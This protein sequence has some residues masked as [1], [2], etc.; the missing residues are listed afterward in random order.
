[1]KNLKLSVI[2]CAVILLAGFNANTQDANEILQKVDKV[3]YSAKDQQNKVTIILIDKNGEESKPEA[4]VL[5]KGNDIRL[6]EPIP[7]FFQH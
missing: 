3:L 1:M 7:T 4:D 5:Q 2:V 6:H